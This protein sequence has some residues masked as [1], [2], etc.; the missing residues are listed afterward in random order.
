MSRI[1]RENSIFEKLLVML[2]NLSEL[3]DVYRAEFYTLEK[4]NMSETDYL[5]ARIGEFKE[6]VYR[7][8]ENENLIELFIK[9]YNNEL[10][11]EWRV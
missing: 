10:N 8:V 2:Y 11:F 5:K 1:E 4:E 3:R 9:L 7:R 6:M